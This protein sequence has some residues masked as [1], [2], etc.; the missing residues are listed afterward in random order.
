MVVQLLDDLETVEQ[1]AIILYTGLPLRYPY[2]IVYEGQS[3]LGKVSCDL[4]RSVYLV[5]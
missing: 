3:K 5:N 2:R 1:G 4:E